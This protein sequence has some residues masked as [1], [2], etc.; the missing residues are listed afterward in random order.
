MTFSLMLFCFCLHLVGCQSNQK[1]EKDNKS[2]QYLMVLGIAQDAGFPH[3]DNPHEWENYKKGITKKEL[4]TSLGLV[5]LASKQKYLFEATPDM[6]LQLHNLE[7]EHL[8][9]NRLIDGV[10]LTHAHIGHYT[11][12]MHF[13]REAMGAKKIPVFA[14]PKMKIFLEQNGPWS[15]LVSLKNIEIFPTENESLVELTPN[16]NVTPFLVPHRDEFS[17]TVGYKINSPAKSALFIPD[18]NK[19]KLWEKDIVEEVKK[20]DYAF[21]DATFLKNGEIPRDMSEVP[22]PFIEETIALFKSESES[23]KSKIIFIHFNHS[24]Q[25]MNRDNSDRK[26]LEKEGFHFAEEGAI[27]PM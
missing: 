15:Q 5:D 6:P 23:I 21:L 25:A 27:F 3:I 11:G 19:W 24:N 8:K 10:F 12:L 22:H 4:A 26:L 14:M 16:L 1:V 2:K 7:S 20:V 17:E 9:T 13:G 18:I